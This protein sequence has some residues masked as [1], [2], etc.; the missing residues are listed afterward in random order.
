MKK[1]IFISLIFLSL[2]SFSQGIDLGIKVGAN[3]T[4]LTDFPNVDTKTGLNLGAFFTI[5]FND[6]IAIQADALY[7][8]QGAELDLGK[9][10]LSYVNVPVVFKY[11]L[12]K[13]LI[14]ILVLK[15]DS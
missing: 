11:Y 14:Y 5:K 12:I 4:T 8:Q 1:I 2:K 10:D 9:V 6:K 7:S 13:R 15:L 3:F